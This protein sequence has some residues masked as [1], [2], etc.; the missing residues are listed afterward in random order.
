MHVTC[1]IFRAG[2]FTHTVF[3][4]SVQRPRGIVFYFEAVRVKFSFKAI[5]NYIWP[6][7]SVFYVL[8]GLYSTILY[9]WF[10]LHKMI[11]KGSICGCM[12]KIH[13]GPYLNGLNVPFDILS[14]IKP[15]IDLHSRLY[16]LLSSAQGWNYS[17]RSVLA[18]IHNFWDK[19]TVIWN[20]PRIWNV[21]SFKNLVLTKFSEPTTYMICSLCLQWV[22]THST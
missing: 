2:L 7:V 15:V 5:K 20:P 9:R 10:S 6:S 3:N 8:Y 11:F 13:S 12:A 22:I 1:T 18:N 19:Y 16:S 4:V 14:V 21:H 17:I